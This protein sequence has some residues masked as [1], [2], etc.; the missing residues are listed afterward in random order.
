MAASHSAWAVALAL[1]LLTGC[2]ASK[3]RVQPP[4]PERASALPGWVDLLPGMLLKL[5]RAYFNPPE[6][7]KVQDYVGLEFVRYRYDTKRSLRV[8]DESALP[9]R[10]VT[11]PAAGTILP[12]AQLRARYH[13]LIYQVTFDKQT[14]ASSAV[15][16]SAGSESALAKR[17]EVLRRDGRCSGLCTAIPESASA[18]LFI[19]ITVN[20]QPSA[21]LWGST[22]ASVAGRERLLQLLRPAGGKLVPIDLETGLRLPLMPGDQ[23]RF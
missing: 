15:L 23:L 13:R 2:R 7:R 8:L 6:S 21:V 12:A 4:I 22:P 11:Q 18:S 9:A 17:Y 16:L 3:V 5:D 19:E 20:G 1:A 14:G 10:P